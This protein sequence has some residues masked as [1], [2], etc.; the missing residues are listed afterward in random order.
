M[1]AHGIEAVLSFTPLL[2]VHVC[3]FI[4]LEKS[5][6]MARA[7]K[8]VDVISSKI[9]IPGS[10]F[11]IFDNWIWMQCAKYNVNKLYHKQRR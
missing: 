7:I 10:S 6:Y 5:G 2:F 4:F 3:I 11:C 9:G 1:I 8:M